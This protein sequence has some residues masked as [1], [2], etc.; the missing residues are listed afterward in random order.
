MSLQ[1]QEYYAHSRNLFWSFAETLLG[2]PKNLPYRVRIVRLNQLKIGLWDVFAHCQRQG[3][4][5][6]VIK[7]AVV[8][9]FDWLLGRYPNI[10]QIALNGRLAQSTYQKAVKTNVS[11]H[12]SHLKVVG[13][14]S[15]SPANAGIPREQ[16]LNAWQAALRF[17]GLIA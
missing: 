2:I 17:F 11:Q 5:D 12:L 7:D 1:A 9:D 4:S 10:K 15:T 3:S 6:S 8:N 13:L 16:K 14:P